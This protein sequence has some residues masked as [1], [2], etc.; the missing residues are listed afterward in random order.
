MWH[1]AQCT[2]SFD[3]IEIRCKRFLIPD[4]FIRSLES[5]VRRIGTVSLHDFPGSRWS[6][7][8]SCAPNP[9]STPPSMEFGPRGPP[10][11]LQRCGCLGDAV[12]DLLNSSTAAGASD[13]PRPLPRS[14]SACRHPSDGHGVARVI[15]RVSGGCA[16][17]ALTVCGGCRAAPPTPWAIFDSQL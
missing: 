7:H 4:A 3:R 15:R 10:A 12:E 13:E 16:A 11:P 17:L 6:V 14:C 9:K 1:A 8:S 2:F 5:Q